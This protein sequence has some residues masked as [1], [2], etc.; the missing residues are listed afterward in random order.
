M[1]IIN[2]EA[3]VESQATVFDGKDRHLLHEPNLY[4]WAKYMEF[5]D[6]INK[7]ENNSSKAKQLSDLRIWAL[8]K[9]VPSINYQELMMTE[10]IALSDIVMKVFSE[11]IESL[12]KKTIPL[13][14][15]I[16]EM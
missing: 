12:G 16:K 4:E 6:L 13:E 10:F 1:K 14:D 15:T 9:L 2:L 8:T 5:I 7:E 3:M 11:G